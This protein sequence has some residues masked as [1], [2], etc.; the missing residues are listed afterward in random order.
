MVRVRRANE[1]Q[2]GIKT[3][4]LLQPS[5]LSCIFINIDLWVFVFIQRLSIYFYSVLVRA[6]I[7]KNIVAHE[8]PVPGDN[9]CLHDLERKTDVRIGVYVRKRSRQVEIFSGHCVNPTSPPP[10]ESNPFLQA[11]AFFPCL[12][13]PQTPALRRQWARK[14]KCREIRRVWL[15]R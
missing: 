12:C 4:K 2:V 3:E 11:L 9:V 15:P 6:G 13:R 14:A 8:P 5:E 7:E 10:P 1:I